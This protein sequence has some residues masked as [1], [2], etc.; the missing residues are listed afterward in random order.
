MSVTWSVGVLPS[1]F[2]L[3]HLGMPAPGSHPCCS[4]AE[5]LRDAVRPVC[6]V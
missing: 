4:L 6:G 5:Q 2:L 1:R 3:H